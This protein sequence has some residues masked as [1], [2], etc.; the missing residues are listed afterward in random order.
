M[1]DMFHL[2]IN[3]YAVFG[4]EIML[5]IFFWQKYQTSTGHKMQIWASA[6]RDI[7]LVYRSGFALKLEQKNLRNELR[8]NQIFGCFPI[9]E[10]RF[11]MHHSCA[12][13]L[14]NKI[15]QTF[16]L[17]E[18]LLQNTVSRMSVGLSE[19]CTG[20]MRSLIFIIFNIYNFIYFRV[21]LHFCS[22]V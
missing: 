21:Y 3:T 17:D 22:F 2:V 8:E 15:D 1:V 18:N 7:F 12:K 13:N 4:V 5:F 6:Y 11:Q 10:K 9:F 14:Q 20:S 19:N 16:K